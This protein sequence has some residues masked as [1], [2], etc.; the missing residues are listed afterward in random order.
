MSAVQSSTASYVDLF[1]FFLLVTGFNPAWFGHYGFL[2]DEE[3]LRCA[4]FGW[5]SERRLRSWSE[6]GACDFVEYL[7]YYVRWCASLQ[8]LTIC[9]KSSSAYN[10]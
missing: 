7:Y 4:P 3:H 10:A 5:R 9:A 8:P 2:E 1:V 6:Y